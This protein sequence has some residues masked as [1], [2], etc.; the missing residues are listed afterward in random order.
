MPDPTGY[1]ELHILHSFPPSNVNR[2]DLNQPK[3]GY[4]GGRRRAR[5]S[6][7]CFKRAIRTNPIFATT[8][9]VENGDRTR[10]IVREL[11]DRLKAAPE[12][13]ALVV[14]TE[15]ARVQQ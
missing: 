15:F 8:T 9:Q 10:L 1:I 12:E 14:A 2:D 11:R 7:Q 3:D 6:S 13:D 5:V 4:F